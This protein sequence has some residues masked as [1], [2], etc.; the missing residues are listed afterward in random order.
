VSGKQFPRTI[1]AGVLPLAFGLWIFRGVLFQHKESFFVFFDNV[2]QFYPWYQKLAASVHLGYL[3]LWDANPFGGRSFPGEYQ[4]GVFYPLNLIWCCFFGTSRG[5]GIEY[6]EM[7]VCLHFFVASVGFFLL[8]HEWKL[9]DYASILAGLVYA[10]SG[11]VLS[12]AAGQVCIF[13]G[14]CL[15]PWALWFVFKYFRHSK[16]R[17]LA[18]AGVVLALQVLAGHIQPFFHTSILIVCF[19]G[20]RILK[21]TQ[22]AVAFLKVMSRSLLW[23]YVPCAV[24]TLPQ[25]IFGLYYLLHAYRWVGSAT[26]IG[27]GQAVP[28][29]T[30]AYKFC[31]SPADFFNLIDPEHFQPPDGNLI[32]FGILPLMLVLLFLASP[33]WRNLSAS[34]QAHKWLLLILYVATVVIMLGHHTVGAAL[35]YVILPISNLSRELGRYAIILHFLNCILVGL[36]LDAIGNQSPPWSGR[37]KVVLR[38]VSVLA[39]VEIVYLWRQAMVEGSVSHAIGFRAQRMLIS[40]SLAAI[41]FLALVLVRKR[42]PVK[43]LLSVCVLA[44]LSVHAPR[45]IPDLPSQDYAPIVFRR[46]EVIDYLEPYYGSARVEIRDDA[47]PPNIGDVYRIQT[48]SG[49]GATMYQ[50]YFDFLC[51][52]W[53]VDSRVNDLLNVRFVV[54]PKELPLKQI[55]HDRERNVYLYERDHYLPRVF[56][57]NALAS[58]G[59]DRPAIAFRILEYRDLCQR[60]E[61]DCANEEPVIF[62]EIRYPGWKARVDGIETPIAAADIEG[63][64]NLFRMLRVTAGKHLVEFRYLMPF[65]PPHPGR[66]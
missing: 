53:N 50:P 23:I 58:A 20:C 2:N 37:L 26:P 35:L 43:W 22:G 9:D 25:N 13:Y 41:C 60:Y 61:I 39:L 59:Q 48:K 36:A 27:P 1:V 8:C 34:F 44:E 49:H 12:R 47:L 42:E 21:E 66:S 38:L 57:R 11:A 31:F 19:A 18:L 29:A 7:L 54:S 33:Q 28:Y 46:T 55:L 14:L 3:P 24:L 52:D 62:S 51:R 63:S 30:F 15:L 56:T 4:T 17:F 32:F 10:C 6:L 45:S 64:E 5:I 65:S 40:W 16:S